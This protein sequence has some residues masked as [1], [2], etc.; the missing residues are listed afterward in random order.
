VKIATLR[1]LRLLALLALGATSVSVPLRAGA[2]GARIELHP[3]PTTTLS[4][5]EFLTG[6]GAGKPDLIAGELRIPTLGSER[7]LSS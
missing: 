3:L 2:Q 7:L 1:V 6:T 4:N 5:K